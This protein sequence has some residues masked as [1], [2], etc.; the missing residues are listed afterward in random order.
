[1]TDQ[2]VRLELD[3]AAFDA[4]RFEQYLTRCQAAGI[5]LTTLAELGDTPEHRRALYELNKECSADIPER[6]EF[7]SYEEYAERRFASA[8][9]DPRGVVVALDGDVWIGMAATSVHED[10]VFNEMTGVRA[11]YRGRGIAIAMKTWGLRFAREYGAPRVRTF[12]HPAN[13][14]AIAM[15]RRM[16]FVDAGTL[17]G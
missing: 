6:G 16:G 8:G 14:N 3:V 9:Y 15:N 10:F 5:R 2:W 13:A 12:H 17:D 7:Y 1:M 11:A 4:P